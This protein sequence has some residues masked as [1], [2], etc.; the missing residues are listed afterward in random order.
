V[1]PPQQLRVAEAK[2]RDAGRGKARINDDTMLALRIAAGD[3]I[4]INGK[5]LTAAIAWPAY[6]EDQQNNIIRIDGLLRKNAGVAINE[7]V[8]IAKADVNEAKSVILAPVDMRLNVDKDFKNFVKSRLL[9]VPVVEGDALFVV[10][11]GSAMPFTVVTTTPQGIVRIGAATTINVY[12]YPE[13]SVQQQRDALRHQ[14]FA[15]LQAQERRYA[16]DTTCFQIPDLIDHPEE[17][18]VLEKARQVAHTTQTPVDILVELREQRGHIATLPWARIDPD[19]TITYTYPAPPRRGKPAPREPRSADLTQ[20]D[21]LALLI[22]TLK[23]HEQRIDQLSQQLDT[24][25]AEIERR[26]QQPPRENEN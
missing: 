23:T 16:A 11:L 7:Y 15:W 6:P 22:T 5:R 9:E 24:L 20:L 13:T 10:I 26:R 4:A 25:L 2:Q 8:V 3:I 14:R 17:S 21:T 19:G 12:D 18:P 1:T